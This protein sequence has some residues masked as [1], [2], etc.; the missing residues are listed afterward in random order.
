MHPLITNNKE[1]IFSI[2]EQNHVRSLFFFGSV[3]DTNKFTDQSDID[4]LVSFEEDLSMDDYTDCYFN[5]IFDLEDLLGRK[6]DIT[7]ERSI[8][9]PYFKEELEKT[10]VLF[11]DSL[12][13]VDGQ[14]S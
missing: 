10:K 6:I 7:T 3:V 9:K 13:E 4:I 1:K 2:C 12:A 5:L 8:T 11:Y 14:S